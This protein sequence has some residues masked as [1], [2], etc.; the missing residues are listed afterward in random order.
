[1]FAYIPSLITVALGI[2]I[3]G[4]IYKV[5]LP[6]L[7]IA[8]AIIIMLVVAINQNLSFFSND[9]GLMMTTGSLSDAA[10]YL[11]IGALILFSLIYIF[12]LKGVGKSKP[13]NI[14]S[15]S[16][17]PTR[18]MSAPPAMQN[19]SAKSSGQASSI[20]EKIV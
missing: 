4:I 10:P 20:L 16:P 3:V 17:K 7:V 8:V 14:P 2:G 12:I 13:V 5:H 15:P 11:I 6:L 19:N 1:M 9:Y 18:N